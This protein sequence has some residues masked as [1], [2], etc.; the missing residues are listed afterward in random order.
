MYILTT[1]NP[2]DGAYAITNNYGEKI[3]Y[4]FEEEDDAERYLGMLEY[5]D[6]PEMQIT[7]VNPEVA[8]L[9]CERMDYRYVIITPED[10]VVPPDYAKVSNS[11]I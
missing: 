4:I 10:I 9:A 8:I 11:K 2:E 1:C 6:Y 5:S 3:L 7:E